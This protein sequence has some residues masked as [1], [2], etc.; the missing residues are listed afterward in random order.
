MLKSLTIAAV[1]LSALSLSPVP[2]ITG[3]AHAQANCTTVANY[4]PDE[5]NSSTRHCS[6]QLGHLRRV[7]EEDLDAVE[8][9]NRVF[10][11]PI[12]ADDHMMRSDGNAGAL[13]QV[14]AGNEALVEALW[15]K[16]YRHEDVIAIR[17]TGEESTNL[18]VFK[19]P[20]REN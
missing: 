6:D 3:A 12:C 15:R 8:D 9:P 2:L 4:C 19:A 14:I 13:L 5:P 16:G 17:M 20:Y 7:Y 18:Y 11:I 1:T 10:V